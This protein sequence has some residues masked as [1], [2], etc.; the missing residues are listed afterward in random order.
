LTTLDFNRE[1]LWNGSTYRK[2]EKLLIIY[3]PS[4]VGRKRFGVLWYTNDKV[5]DMW[6]LINLHPN[7]LF[8]E[9][10]FRTLG[11]LCPQIFTCARHSPRLASAHPKWGGCPP[12]KF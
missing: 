9:I 6:T 5:I 12:K 3:N 8:R 4:H 10:T 7:A 2:S 1:Y 11:V